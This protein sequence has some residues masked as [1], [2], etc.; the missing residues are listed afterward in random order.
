M[1]ELKIQIEK[2]NEKFKTDLVLLQKENKIL[3]KE[4]KELKDIL[5]TIEKVCNKIRGKK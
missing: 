2:V 1:E 5:L 4:V 3:K